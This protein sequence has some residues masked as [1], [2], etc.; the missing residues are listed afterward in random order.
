M[1]VKN[2]IPI[3][4]ATAIVYMHCDRF[5]SGPKKNII[6]KLNMPNYENYHSN[7]IKN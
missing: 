7:K 1:N 2:K 3:V 5:T 6:V 4:Y